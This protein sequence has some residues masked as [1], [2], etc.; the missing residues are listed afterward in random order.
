[1]GNN[2]IV[3]NRFEQQE[4]LY[5]IMRSEK[6]AI[7]MIL[8]FILFIATFNVIGSLSMLILEKRKDIAILKSMGA[9]EKLIKR[10]FLLQGMMVSFGGALIGMILGAA[11]CWVQQK[12]GIVKIHTEG[13][14]F[15]IDA[16][17]VVMQTMDFVYVFIVVSLIGLLAAWFPVRNIGR[18]GPV[19]QSLHQN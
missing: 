5:K 10:I 11:I 1:M 8:G 12:F 16:Y 13:G 19:V 17:P 3:K 4:M 18:M 7:F 2:F 6:W 15:L 14:S 9:G